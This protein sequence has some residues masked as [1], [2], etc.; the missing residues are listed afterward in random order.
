MILQV[1]LNISTNGTDGNNRVAR[2]FQKIQN[3]EVGNNNNVALSRFHGNGNHLDDEVT[4]QRADL[5][6][7]KSECEIVLPDARSAISR[8]RTN[9]CKQEISDV[10]CRMQNNTLLPPNIPRFCP[11]AISELKPEQAPKLTNMDG[12]EP[13]RICYMLVVHGRAYRQFARL[14]KAIYHE[15]HFYYIHVDKRSDY[16][17]RQIS[18]ATSIYG[19]V[20]LTKWRMSTIWGGASL[21]QM[22]LRAI[23][24]SLYIWKEWDFFIN[25]SA[26]D[27]PIESDE[28]LSKFLSVNRAKSFLKSHGRPDEKKF[29]K[30]QGLNRVFVECD[31]HMWRLGARSI[32]E[33][34]KMT[35]GSDWLALNRELCTYAITAKDQ[36]VYDLKDWYQYTLLPVES[37]FHTLAHNREKCDAFVDNNLRVTNWNRARGCKCQYKHIV[38]WCGCS[39]NDFFPTDLGRLKTTRPVFF[40]RKFEESVNQEV[41]N[42]LDFRIYGQYPSGTPALNSYWENTY[43]HLDGLASVSDVLMTMYAS[44]ARLGLD[45]LHKSYVNAGQESNDEVAEQCRLHVRQVSTVEMYKRSEEFVGY[46]VTVQAGWEDEVSGVEQHQAVRLQT[47]VSPRPLLK[48][49][50]AESELVRRLASAN[51]GT[52][53]DVKEL[54]LRDWGG[55]IGP[56]SS[57]HLIARWRKGEEDFVVTTAVIDPFNVVADYTDF[58]APSKTAGVT[59]TS[60]SLRKPLRPGKWRVVFYAQRNFDKPA[61][62]L[63]FHVSPLQYRKGVTGDGELV[64][65][66][67]GVLDDDQLNS[68]GHNLVTMR[69]TLDLKRDSRIAEETLVNAS[70]VA[71]PLL[72]GWI[73]HVTSGKWVSRDFCVSRHAQRGGDNW[74]QLMPRGC[75]R[76]MSEMPRSC[77]STQWSSLSPD[78]KS[79]LGAVRGNGRIR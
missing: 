65:L 75:R 77:E 20:R 59:E 49:I 33:G 46:V 6:H 79:Q 70:H 52:N 48:V 40:A 37:F 2:V 51:V 21:L 26:L 34:I 23:K 53:W 15:R 73:D 27:F 36:L 5:A 45:H 25:L 1:F 61:A 44:Y 68:A 69:S 12:I 55:I 3:Q 29:I 9:R 72:H 43:D 28:A 11:I 4:R 35:G 50:D 22:L 71:G 18:E 39:P 47:L 32:P 31:E 66:N 67:S 63:D 74:Q 42:I 17:H 60:L 56:E 78:P 30:K 41:I 57:I 64:N 76:L 14:F 16:L 24:E 8:A 54:V 7:Y 19:N 13:V 62:Q 58:R 38:D 10:A